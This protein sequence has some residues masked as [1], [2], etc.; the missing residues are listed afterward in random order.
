MLGRSTWQGRIRFGRLR[1]HSSPS[2]ISSD[3]HPQSIR[4]GKTT[5]L[6]RCPQQVYERLLPDLEPFPLPQGWTIH[7]AGDHE[8]YL[9][10]RNRSL[11]LSEA[12]VAGK[13]LPMKLGSLRLALRTGSGSGICPP[14]LSLRSFVLC[15]C[16]V[17]ASTCRSPLCQYV[18]RDPDHRCISSRRS[19]ARCCSL[20]RSSS[21]RPSLRRRD[22]R[23]LFRHSRCRHRLATLR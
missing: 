3:R 4:P 6:P 9:Y 14:I 1:T 8:K 5:F 17:P 19:L 20:A 16:T 15:R 21:A 2:T 23:R 7:D 13:C 11:K 10:F 22:R 18:D 12:A